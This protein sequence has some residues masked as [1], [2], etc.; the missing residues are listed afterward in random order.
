[1]RQQGLPGDWV[2]GCVSARA[3]ETAREGNVP[4]YIVI[5]DLVCEGDSSRVAPEARLDLSKQ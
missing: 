4:V 2:T 1:M 5:A 3:G